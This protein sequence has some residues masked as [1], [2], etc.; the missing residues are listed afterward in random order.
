MLKIRS[1]IFQKKEIL[2]FYSS[3]INSFSNSFINL[4][5]RKKEEGSS[6]MLRERERERNM[7]SLINVRHRD[8]GSPPKD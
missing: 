2:T 5:N 6:K 3:G 7:D 4:S 8:I 1:T